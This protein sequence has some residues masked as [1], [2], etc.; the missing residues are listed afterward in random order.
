[1]SKRSSKNAKPATR[2]WPVL[3]TL[4]HLAPNSPMRTNSPAS[5][6]AGSTFHTWSTGA[7]RARGA[8]KEVGL[9]T[10]YNSS[11]TTL[12]YRLVVALIWAMK[13]TKWGTTGISPPT[14]RLAALRHRISL[15]MHFQGMAA[16]R[17]ARGRGDRR[18]RTKEEGQGYGVMVL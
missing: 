17:R 12:S 7:T 16:A 13:D 9:T 8:N 10:H 1:M 18:R 2:K 4:S 5:H 15:M 11:T 14:T 6:G 3:P